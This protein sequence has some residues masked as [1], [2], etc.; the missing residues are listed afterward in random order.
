M[1]PAV[2]H[3][4][5]LGIRA[6]T[7]QR[8]VA[9]GDK[10]DLIECVQ[11]RVD[12]PDLMESWHSLGWISTFR[13]GL[14]LRGMVQKMRTTTSPT[15][16][17]LG[18]GLCRSFWIED[19]H[20]LPLS[21]SARV[22]ACVVNF[23][24]NHVSFKREAAKTAEDHAASVAG[25]L[26]PAPLVLTHRDLAPRNLMVD[27]SNRLWII[28]WDYAGWYPAYFEYASMHNFNVPPA[29]GLLDRYRWN[30]FVW[31]ATGSHWKERRVLFEAQRKAI[32]FPAARRFNIKAGATP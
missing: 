12:G 4:I 24:Y 25:P 23:W 1:Q 5:S 21:P 8:V 17:S 20:R 11:L 30:V 32:R 3:A 14:Q 10:D 27:G 15:A 13:L 9:G 7:I 16:G 29:W 18:T 22:I 31:L 28:D 26:A 19:R 2:D 6:P